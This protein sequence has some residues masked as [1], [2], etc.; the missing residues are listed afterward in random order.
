MTIKTLTGPSIQDALAKARRELG[1]D[2]VLLE[3]T[4]ATADGPAEI[5]VAIDPPVGDRKTASASK[6]NV[7]KPPGDG[8]SMSVP[9]TGLEDQ[10]PLGAG[11][12]TDGGLTDGAGNGEN[13]LPDG[14]DGPLDG[15]P[16]NDGSGG[17]RDF[18]QVL[19]R[20]KSLGRGQIFSNSEAQD[21]R[22]E[23]RAA[24]PDRSAGS[25]F[26]GGGRRRG[27]PRS[28]TARRWAQHPLYKAL[29]DKGLKP[30]T[31][32]RLFDELSDRGVDP[33]G[34]FPG[35][36]RWA[37][38][39]LL[40]RRIEVAG[41]D[42]TRD[43]LLLM[44]PG[45]AGKTSL[46]LKMATHD[47]LLAG[48]PPIVVHLRP[49]SD[50]LADYQN[51]T[52]LYK[53]HGVPVRNVRTREDLDQ[54]LRH[55]ERFGRVLIDTP[56]LP[57]PLEK[58]RSVLRR[59]QSILRPLRPLT[60]HFVVDATRALHNLDASVLSHLPVRPSAVAMT[61][62]DEVAKWGRFVEWL[63][64][65]NLP[66]QFVSGGA[67]VPEAARTFSLEWFVEHVMDL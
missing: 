16:G 60:V 49:E 36:M 14:A 32:T 31:V 29:L 34:N 65:L 44:G 2:V 11:L 10:S 57:L 67:D 61:H 58:G 15:P 26:G 35:E 27:S 17:G 18:E 64:T 13:G 51:P 20:E 38:A 42:Q 43:N 28:K 39:K 46:I 21:R 5:A 40:F 25:S 48:G 50:R 52:S 23:G 8:G 54:A 45:G 3:S 30:D 66:I 1:D 53:K 55:T 59:V 37:C 12:E 4:S 9:D 24:R 63:I 56:P 6:G 7:P 22:G 19:E 47:R 62:L 33:T 41:P